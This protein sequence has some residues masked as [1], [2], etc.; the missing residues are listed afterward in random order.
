MTGGFIGEPEDPEGL[1]SPMWSWSLWLREAFPQC[2][3]ALLQQCCPRGFLQQ[4]NRSSRS[5]ECWPEGTVHNRKATKQD[6]HM[7]GRVSDNMTG[8][9]ESLVPINTL[10]K[11]TQGWHKDKRNIFISIFVYSIKWLR[12]RKSHKFLLVSFRWTCH[13]LPNTKIIS[14]QWSPSWWMNSTNGWFH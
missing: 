9:Q 14:F 13:K 10:W 8:L 3:G 6:P 5:D 4:G 2:P 7:S 12:W 11:E 1:F